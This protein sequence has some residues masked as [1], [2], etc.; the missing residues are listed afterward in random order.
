MATT[1]DIATTCTSSSCSDEQLEKNKQNKQNKEQK[2]L[3]QH[4]QGQNEQEKEQENDNRCCKCHRKI[5]ENDLL[6]WN[7]N[8]QLQN[9]QTTTTEAH[10]NKDKSE[11]VSQRER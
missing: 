5:T 6:S 8:L 7:S 10:N 11:K 3:E 2:K 9:S 1:T 4:Q